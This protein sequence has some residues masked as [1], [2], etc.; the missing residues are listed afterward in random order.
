MAKAQ[1]AVDEGNQGVLDADG[2]GFTFDMSQ[3]AAESGFPYHPKG[4]YE[5]SLDSCAYKISQSSGNPMWEIRFLITGPGEE[6]AN[7]KVTVRYYQSFKPD[8]MGRAKLLLTRLG[9]EDLANSTS[10]N[11]KQVADDGTLVGS[12]CKLRLDVRESDEYGT[13]NEVKAVLPANAAAGGQAGSGGF[14]M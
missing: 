14:S 8:Q 12:Q 6:V 3:Q 11:P 13:S 1:A 5:A 2:E 7:K 4:V 9:H 10:F